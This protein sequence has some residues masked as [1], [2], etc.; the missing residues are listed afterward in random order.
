MLLNELDNSNLLGQDFYL[1]REQDNLPLNLRCPRMTSVLYDHFDVGFKSGS[2]DLKIHSP[3]VLPAEGETV[4]F[5]WRNFLDNEA[6]IEELEIFA[7]G[8]VLSIPCGI[9]QPRTFNTQTLQI[10]PLRKKNI[11][12]N[13]QKRKSIKV[14]HK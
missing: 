1:V 10:N 7:E 2:L 6:L 8:S 12:A 5:E 3:L 13:L 11:L 9:Y 14:N 4:Y